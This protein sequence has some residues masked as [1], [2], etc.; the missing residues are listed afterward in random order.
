M[1]DEMHPL[2]AKRRDRFSDNRG[3]ACGIGLIQLLCRTA[4]PWE[5]E[6]QDPPP[7]GEG[8]LCEHPGVEVGT[9]AVEQ[10]DSDTRSFA[11]LDIAQPEAIDLDLPRPCRFGLRPGFHDNFGDRKPGDKAIDV[12]IRH[13]LG[14]SYREQT[15]D[16][17]SGARR[18]HYAPQRAGFRRLEDVGDLRRLDLEELFARLE[19][20]PLLL[21]P[22]DDRAFGHRQPPFRHRDRGD[23]SG[24]LQ[25][26]SRHRER[27]EAISRQP[28]SARRDCF[29]AALLAMTGL[30]SRTRKPRGRPRRSARGSGYRAFPRT[31]RRAPGY[32]G[33]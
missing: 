21:E 10:Q 32:A 16:R 30:T 13:L 4:M 15:A 22:A 33:R 8:G 23:F 7:F 3:E 25:Y 9:K 1:S 14:C 6:C 27:S 31:A 12:A 11:E 5:I 20:L 19:A 2:D 26:S 17:H 28:A 29:V 18:R 24:H